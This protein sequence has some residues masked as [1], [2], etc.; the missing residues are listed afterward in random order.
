MYELSM[1]NCE[2]KNP[3]FFS[4]FLFFK[5]HVYIV[6]ISDVRVNAAKRNMYSSVLF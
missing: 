4:V 2:K 5:S 3:P 6:F 1:F